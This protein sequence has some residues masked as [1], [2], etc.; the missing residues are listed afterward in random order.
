MNKGSLTRFISIWIIGFVLAIAVMTMIT[1]L[2]VNQRYSDNSEAIESRLEE[3]LMIDGLNQRFFM[4]VSNVRGYLAYGRDDFRVNTFESRND[5]RSHLMQVSGLYDA[6]GNESVQRRSDY[7]RRLELLQL[8]WEEY[9]ELIDQSLRM[10]DE[11]RIEDMERISIERATPLISSMNTLLQEL[12]REQTQIVQEL[13]ERNNGFNRLLVALLCLFL[14]ALA[15]FGVVLVRFLRKSVVAPVAK[16]GGIVDLIGT[17]SYKLPAASVRG[18]EIGRL[19]RG[20]FRM[21]R[22]LEEREQQ[23]ERSRLELQ[24]QRDEMEAQNEEI[25][26]QQEEQERT[27]ALLRER[28]QELGFVN[29]FQQK[30]TGYTDIHA[31]VRRTVSDMLQM[32][33]QDAA[34]LLTRDDSLRDDS[35]RDQ[36]QGRPRS[37]FRIM[38]AEGYP[39]GDASAPVEL[40]G[41][42]RRAWESGQ[43]LVSGREPSP[44][45]CGLHGA[46]ASAVDHYYPLADNEGQVRGLLLLTK[47]GVGELTGSD[48]RRASALAGQFALAFD[49][50]LASEER[51]QQ[52]DLIRSIVDGVDEGILM[53]DREGSI[54]V[55]NNRL[56]DLLP[57]AAAAGGGDIEGYL[58]TLQQ[59]CVVQERTLVDYWRQMYEGSLQEVHVRF[60]CGD[61]EPRHFDLYVNALQDER[62]E[63]IGFLFVFR[64]RSEEERVD[65]MKNEFISIVSHE[66]RTPLASVIGFVEILLHRQV[67]PEKQR[68]YLETVYNEAR[69]L[70]TLLNDFL[71]LRRIEAGKQTYH[72]VP[73]HIAP[74]VQD[75]ARR[76][77]QSMGRVITVA[78]MTASGRDTVEADKD[79]LT[80]VIENVLSNAVKY[81]PGADRVDVR[82]WS[83][84][85]RVYIDIEDYGLGIS[86]DAAGHIFTRFYRSD[87]SDVR[88][89]GGTGLGLSIAR[90]IARDHD[91]DI[92]FTSEPGRGSTF[93]IALRARIA[94]EGSDGDEK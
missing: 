92:T 61:G 25:A 43:P 54:V 27:L 55:S 51:R 15:V 37:G 30:L 33:G 16:I 28:E 11:N 46:Y 90:Q 14:I 63:L 60:A 42:A 18:D 20:V 4:L 47:Y 19:E 77:E 45:E 85:T 56:T 84:G 21:A 50:Q 22:Q 38:Y 65:E 2:F 39:Q 9:D 93:T 87:N 29:A 83:E 68:S 10:K 49:T 52:R 36:A 94:T 34:L 72:F 24:E 67:S 41:A 89:I 81:S 75:V 17:G 71:D 62:G 44:N 70:S 64:D 7:Q 74:L 53:C 76:I 13:V 79:R 8:H 58:R 31:F 5:F 6:Y 32:L 78:N 66:L 26:A 88:S 12:A 57:S 86:E 82:V 3:L 91:G 59:S 35:P 80:Q 1:G 48:M 23:Q 73:L 69:R 40:F